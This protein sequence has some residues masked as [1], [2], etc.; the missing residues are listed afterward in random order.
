MRMNRPNITKM[1]KG[2]KEKGFTL[3]EVIVA[4][5]ILTFGI[6][7]VASMQAASIR[8]NSF[9]SSVTEGTTWAGDQVERLTALPWDDPLLQDTDGDTAA[10]LN[11]TGFDNDPD[12][13]NDADQQAIEGKYTIN[14]NVA[15]NTPITNTKT[16][17]VT[18]TWTDQGVRKTVSLQRVIPRII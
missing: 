14:W 17:N 4:I 3:L 1:R 11:D 2:S 9:S 16:I 7:A 5:S 13:Q 10:G 15:D 18:V 8:G 6:L 12:T